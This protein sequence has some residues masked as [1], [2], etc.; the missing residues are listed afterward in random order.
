MK[1]AGQFATD[2]DQQGPSPSP[3]APPAPAVT[4]GPVVRWV[5]AGEEL[6]LNRRQEII[7]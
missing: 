7:G 3:P 2:P 5:V 1:V 4:R 6:E